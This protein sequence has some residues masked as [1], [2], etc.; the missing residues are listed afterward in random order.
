MAEASAVVEAR[1]A[2]V[3]GRVVQRRGVSAGG[4]RRMTLPY[5]SRTLIGSGKVRETSALA[6]LTGADAV[7]FLNPLT[8]LQQDVLSGLLGCPALSLAEFLS[9]PDRRPPV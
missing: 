6:A 9:G 8:P 4:V 2:R 3:V 1:G 5:S 7:V